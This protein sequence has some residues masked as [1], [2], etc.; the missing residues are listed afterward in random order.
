MLVYF[1]I[2]RSNF[3]LEGQVE[4][5]PN[6]LLLC[7]ENW[8]LSLGILIC[9]QLGH[10][11]LTHHKGVNLTDVKV[12]I[13]QEFLQVSPNWKENAKERWQIRSRCSSGRIVALKCSECGMRTT[14]T[15]GRK[16]LPLGH[17]PW[18][19]GLH[20]NGK[21][22][23]GGALLSRQWIVSAAHCMDSPPNFSNWVALVGLGVPTRSK[24]EAGQAVGKIILHPSYNPV[25]RDY[26]LAMLKLKEPLSLSGAIQAVC[27]PPYHQN[28]S[29]DSACWISGQVYPRQENSTVPIAE[30]RAEMPVVLQ[31]RK[32]CNGSC[33][34]AGEITPRM[35]CAHYLDG[36]I[37]ACKGESGGALVCQHECTQHLVGI[38]I[39]D[40]GCKRPNGPGL[41]TKVASLLDWIHHVM[42]EDEA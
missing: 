25:N 11:Q 15:T 10:L 13:T 28:T 41:Y 26:D 18:Q 9:R 31:S 29:N 23:C 12:G 20:L 4:G 1:R 8:D 22:V 35:L 3:L 36:T 39:Q 32:D 16:D 17:Q 7:H 27:L 38:R 42:E 19:V 34:E 5:L 40:D 30:V 37:G 24:E 33:G 21:R 14:G 6:R 2:N